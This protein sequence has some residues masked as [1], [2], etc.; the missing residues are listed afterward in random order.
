M[1]TFDLGQV[2]G[3]QGP[4]GKDGPQG[5]QGIP[6]ATGKQGIQGEPGPQGRPRPQRGPG[7]DRQ[8]GACG[9]RR[10]H[11]QY[12]SGEHRNPGSWQ[13]GH[14]DT[15]G[16]QPGCGPH[17]RL[18]HPQGSGRG[19]PGRYAQGHLRPHGQGRDIFAYADTKMPKSGGTFTGTVGACLPPAEAP[20]ASAISTSAAALRHP[21]WGPTA[22]SISTSGKGGTNHD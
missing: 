21:A 1:P 2:V 10:Q 5:P 22:T 7:R 3:P 12:P 15:A 18:R 9:R 6:G 17:F 11:P 4:Q 14:G 19:E 8:A 20:R 16:R 13:Q